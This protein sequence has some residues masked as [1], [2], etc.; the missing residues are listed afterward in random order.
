MEFLRFVTKSFGRFFLILLTLTVSF[1]ASG[2]EN[3]LLVEPLGLAEEAMEQEGLF[4]MPQLQ[5]AAIDNPGRATL[6]KALQSSV[7]SANKLQTA[8]TAI[9]LAWVEFADGN[10]QK[11]IQLLQTASDAVI[12]IDKHHLLP[13]AELSL[14]WFKLKNGSYADA[15]GIANKIVTEPNYSKINLIKGAALVVSAQVHLASKDWTNAQQHFLAAS[16]SF[17]PTGMRQMEA[18]CLVQAAEASLRKGDSPERE[19]LLKSAFNIFK[20]LNDAPGM[21]MVLRDQGI[22]FYKKGLYSQ[23]NLEFQKSLNIYPQLSTARLLKDSYLKIS[24]VFTL[25]GDLKAADETKIKYEQVRDSIDRVEASR[26]LNSRST[27]KEIMERNAINDMLRKDINFSMEGVSASDLERNRLLIDAEIER[28]EKEK[29]IEEFNVEKRKSDITNQERDEKIKELLREKQSQELALSKKELQ[30]SQGKAFRD[31]LLAVSV[32]IVIISLLLYNR[33]RNEKRTRQDLDRTFNELSET[34]TKLVATQEQLVHSQ[35]MASLGQLTAGIAHEIQNPLNFV[36]NF[37][38]LSIELIDEMNTAPETEKQV[39]LKDIISNLQ[40][41]NEHGKRA[42][43]IVKGMLTHSRV[44]KPEKQPVDLNKMIDELL[45]LSYH[46]NRSRDQGF[47]SEII[48]NLDPEIP[49]VNVVMQEISRVLVNIFNNAFYAV[50]QR[51]KAGEKNYSATVGV[52][53]R[54]DGKDVVIK[55]RDNGTGMPEDVKNRIFD[56]FFTTKPS[57]EGT[58]LGLSLSYD[59]IVKAHQGTLNVFS[60]PGSFTEFVITL[61]ID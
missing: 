24:T 40:K 36:N 21:A 3:T 38:E 18:R 35:K 58:G 44:G 23:A 25:S 31:L 47:K 4:F 43:R 19:V 9:Q 52:S 55:I 49:K 2:Q 10:T 39:I 42:D 34:H 26:V 13:L 60:E 48:K 57:G 51:F 17:S 20:S 28:L 37:S 27:R 7:K 61:P 22:A 41:I 6:E 32:S 11:S 8:N 29:L 53:T 14:A 46:G 59:T 12:D 1:A 30:V 33:Y 45:E 5:K 15:L 16:K 56:P 54:L 50:H